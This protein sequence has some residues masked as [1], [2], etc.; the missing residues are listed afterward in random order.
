MP[1][2][3]DPATAPSNVTVYRGVDD[4]SAAVGVELGPTDWLTMT[5]DRIDAFADATEDHQWIHVDPSRAS[6]SPYGATIAH[7]FLTLSL[8][9]HFMSSL[10][11]FDRVR[12]G[13]NYGLDKVRFPA[14]VPSGARLRGRMRLDG[15]E[16]LPSN[17]VQLTTTITI[18][19]EG[20]A[21][22]ACVATLVS[23]YSFHD[24]AEGDDRSQS[25]D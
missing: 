11:R 15:V 9:P 22:P 4:L 13:L 3:I 23:R 6:E 12:M 20:N 1:D 7:G 19:V 2:V 14:A 8:V 10:R 25:D 16:P 5:Q 24:T 21:K 18:E 17:G